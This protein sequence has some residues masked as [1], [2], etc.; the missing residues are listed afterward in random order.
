MALDLS[1]VGETQIEANAADPPSA[2]VLLPAD[3]LLLPGSGDILFHVSELG[4]LIL[5]NFSIEHQN[6]TYVL[7]KHPQ[8]TDVDSDQSDLPTNLSVSRPAVTRDDQPPFDSSQFGCEPVEKSSPKPHS[9]TYLSEP[10]ACSVAIESR[11]AVANA[12][13]HSMVSTSLKAWTPFLS[14]SEQPVDATVRRQSSVLDNEEAQGTHDCAHPEINHGDGN[15]S[16]LN[17]LV[18][19]LLEEHG[20]DVKHKAISD[21]LTDDLVLSGHNLTALARFARRLSRHRQ[22]VGL[23]Q[24][25]LS[26]E[27]SEHFNNE[28][29]FSQSLLS[30]FERLEV[31]VRAAFRLLPY[32]ENW[33]THVERNGCAT[34]GLTE[35][36][37]HPPAIRALGKRRLTTLIRFKLKYPITTK[38]SV[39]PCSASKRLEPNGPTPVCE[40]NVCGVQSA[41]CVSESNDTNVMTH[42]NC[43]LEN[44]YSRP[45]RRRRTHFSQEALIML[46]ASFRKNPRPKGLQLTRLAAKTGYDR[47][48]IRVWFCNRR[49]VS[50]KAETTEQ[51]ER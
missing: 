41:G 23:S 35:P 20:L 39:N 19:Q 1:F 5:T 44:P 45:E 30:R 37:D 24:L 32:L 26:N 7:R 11:E 22:Q 10:T 25:Q 8:Q 48:A 31:T 38:S 4:E 40:S 2:Y 3:Y 28:A 29:M 50:A 17:R 27:L 14:A 16:I 49:Q 46:A 34:A 36:G 15:P 13:S 9:V 12:T 51:V 42:A 6:G 18:C 47:E 21:M 33:L 43:R